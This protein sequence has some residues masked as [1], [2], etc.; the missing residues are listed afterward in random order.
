MKNLKPVFSAF[1]VGALLAM[2]GGC[3]DSNHSN[4]SATRTPDF[5][6]TVT[7]LSSGQP[8][9]PLAVILHREGYHAFMPGEAATAGL[10]MLAEGGNNGDLVA[11]AQG[12]STVL[13]TTTGSAALAPG[14]SSRFSL[15]APG[16]D[17]RLT[18]LGMLVNSNDGFAALSGA[19]L[20]TLAPGESLILHGLAYDAGTEANTETATT[21]PGQG[22]EGFNAARDDGDKVTVHP[23]IVSKDDGLATSALAAAQRFDNPVMRVVVRRNR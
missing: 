10:E 17:I 4:D 13:A 5:E 14:E 9:S 7:N 19:D 12:A 8:F 23:G 2:L 6:I 3:H 21:V 11:A 1:F 16:P 20:G 22:G 15:T 18:V